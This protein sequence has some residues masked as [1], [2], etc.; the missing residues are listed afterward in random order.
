MVPGSYFQGPGYQGPMSQDSKL[1]NLGSQFQGSKSQDSRF[2]SPGSRILG[3]GSRVSRSR[4][5]EPRSQVL[6]L[7][8]AIS[9]RVF[10][11]VL[12]DTMEI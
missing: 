5:P 6:I 1:Q 9:Y 4:V 2:Q 11:I 10:N 8:Y 7:D 3:L 12:Q